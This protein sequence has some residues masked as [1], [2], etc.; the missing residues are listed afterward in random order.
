MR[1]RLSPPPVLATAPRYAL[2]PAAQM[3]PESVP[4]C[5]GIGAQVLRNGC[6]DGAGISAQVRPESVP[7]WVRNTQLERLDHAATEMSEGTKRFFAQATLCQ[8]DRR[9]PHY[10]AQFHSG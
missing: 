7:R 4:K 5:S 1:P 10:P 8:K 9:R 2:R 3:Q 6:P